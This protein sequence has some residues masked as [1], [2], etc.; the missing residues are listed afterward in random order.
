MRHATLPVVLVFLTGAALAQ[1][2]GGAYE[3]ELRRRQYEYQQQQ[4]RAAQGYNDRSSQQAQAALQA[5]QA[6]QARQ[7]QQALQAQLQ[8]QQMLDAM[9]R[10]QRE[11]QT[12][13]GGFGSGDGPKPQMGRTAQTLG[14]K[15]K[16]QLKK[17]EEAN[18]K[19]KKKAA[20]VRAKAFEQAQRAALRRGGAKGAMR[21]TRRNGLVAFVLSFKGAALV[22]IVGA[23]WLTQREALIK[24]IGMGTKYPLLLVSTLLRKG[25]DILL[26][27]LLRK[28]LVARSQSAEL[29]GGS[30]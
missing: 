3:A 14:K 28:V 26:K 25:W 27:P 4:L 10:A 19:Q 9:R 12:A 7:A 2:G 15:E 22:G 29:P 23:M 13:H 1:Q 17:Q 21:P 11:S 8:Q 6:Q 20:A 16:A 5:Q 30:Y 18:A 24:I